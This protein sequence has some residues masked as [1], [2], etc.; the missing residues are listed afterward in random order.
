MDQLDAAPIEPVAVRIN[1]ACRLIDCGRTK[2]Y[3]L[4]N[5]GALEVVDVGGMKRVTMA[6]IRDLP[7]KS[8][9]R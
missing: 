1:T 3:E 8:E 9:A 5:S 4:I 2:V 6:S 7:K